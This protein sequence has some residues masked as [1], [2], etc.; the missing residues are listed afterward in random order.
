M[1]TKPS[2]QTGKRYYLVG[3]NLLDTNTGYSFANEA[4][5]LIDGRTAGTHEYRVPGFERPVRIGI[6]PLR[7]K[8]R[9]IVRG[10]VRDVRDYY[11][12]R[13]RF[14]STRAKQLVERIDP[15]GF[16]FA[17]CETFDIRGTPIQS[18]WWMEAIRW[19]EKFDEERSVF[20]WTRDRFPAAP[21]AQ[22]NP[23][24]FALHEMRM[25]EG[26]PEE[27]HAFWLAHYQNY[28]V[29]DEV[30]ADAWRS[31]GLK[32]AVFTPLQTP[33]EAE[34]KDHNLFVNY[35]YWTER[36]QVPC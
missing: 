3:Q 18:Y 7:E 6:P 11:G 1:T 23:S 8:P 20:E 30:L 4:E 12:D 15:D 34:M 10:K 26:F 24:I 27:Y 33:S 2:E 16:E 32:G 19:V 21:D 36:A 13:P 35:P 14:V 22:N 25:S 31:E 5:A 17:E 9:L 29:F 28:V